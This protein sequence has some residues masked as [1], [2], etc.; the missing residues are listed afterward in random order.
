MT[1]YYGQAL[2]TPSETIP[3]LAPVTAVTA[4]VALG[5][6]WEEGSQDVVYALADGLMLLFDEGYKETKLG[7]TFCASDLIDSDI[8]HRAGQIKA[9]NYV[10]HVGSWSEFWTKW[11]RDLQARV[12]AGK[13]LVFISDGVV[14]LHQQLQQSYPDSTHI[15]DFYHAMEHLG[16]LAQV[17]ISGPK[18][19]QA[20]LELQRN[21]LLDSQLDKV[22]ANVALLPVG[23]DT[24]GKVCTYLENNRL[25]MDY[26]SYLD[27]G[28]CIG[29]G[30]IESANKAIVQS[31]LKKSGQRWSKSGAQHVLDL[32][33]CWMS[34][35]WGRLLALIEPYS[36]AM[37][38]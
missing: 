28:W 32:R 16:G 11:Q 14:W 31:R 26:K 3:A 21:L 8:D 37:A 27:Q 13:R 15:L 23:A 10:G 1:N 2:S 25:R 22:L 9:S 12:D 29:S 24:S 19:R 5:T 34:G 36:Y 33:T 38:A 7:R 20:W 30:A 6:L 17:G 35:D 18:A 4:L